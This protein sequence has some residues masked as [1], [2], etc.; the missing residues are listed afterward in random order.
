[1]PIGIAKFFY[2]EVGDSESL[3]CR[4]SF[5]RHWPYG[6]PK[7]I[8]RRHFSREQ[9]PVDS[10][11]RAKGLPAISSRERFAALFEGAKIRVP[12]RDVGIVKSKMLFEDRHCERRKCNIT[13]SS[14]ALD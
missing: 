1:M 4:E 12:P 9:E 8:V 11:E 7:F 2:G 6:T 5:T 13:L 3:E 10:L 14:E